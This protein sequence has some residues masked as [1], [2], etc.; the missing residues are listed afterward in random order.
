MKKH[1]FNNQTVHWKQCAAYNRVNG[2]MVV[3]AGRSRCSIDHGLHRKLVSHSNFVFIKIGHKLMTK[4]CYYYYWNRKKILQVAFEFA[5]MCLMNWV[6]LCNPEGWVELALFQNYGLQMLLCSSAF[7][8]YI[9]LN[10]SVN[11]KKRGMRERRKNMPLNY[12]LI[13]LQ[14]IIPVWMLSWSINGVYT[15]SLLLW[16]FAGTC[17]WVESMQFKYGSLFFL[18]DNMRNKR[19]LRYI[20]KNFHSGAVPECDFWMQG[21]QHFSALE[22]S[23]SLVKIEYQNGKK[24]FICYSGNNYHL[25]WAQFM[26]NYGFLNIDIYKYDD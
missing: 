24:A 23:D 2:S 12:C 22:Q 26:N 17:Y 13:W 16:V 6:L 5:A 25:A 1:S 20:D 8:R 10:I 19:Y 3:Q 11:T 15:G 9:F 14:N 7:C 4:R 21:L 18:P